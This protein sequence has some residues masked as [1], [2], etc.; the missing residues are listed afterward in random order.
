MTPRFAF[1]VM[2]G[3]SLAGCNLIPKQ[4][5]EGAEAPEGTVVVPVDEARDMPIDD[6][7]QP[8]DAGEGPVLQALG[9]L[10]GVDL[11]PRVGGCTFQHS[12]GRDLLITGAAQATNA[13]ARGAVRSGGV[14]VMLQSADP[15]GVD[16]LKSGAT[17]SDGTVT[18]Q[19]RR[20]AGEAR[21][22]G[23]VTIWDANLGVVDT[24]GKKRVYAPGKWM[25][26]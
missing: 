13:T 6:K 10:T 7:G 18:V 12:D 9:N 20:A 26:A 22:E 15:I 3:A 4:D 23:G 19:V 21:S 8:V 24:S 11:G 25:C 1:V 14:V 2:L 16:G 17:L 5:D